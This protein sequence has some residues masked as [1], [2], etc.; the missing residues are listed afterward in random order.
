MCE[1]K[2]KRLRLH[3]F[4]V[5]STVFIINL[6]KFA[7]AAFIY[8]GQINKSNIN[9]NCYKNMCDSI[10]IIIQHALL[11]SIHCFIDL[12]PNH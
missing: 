5:V 1:I 8:F 6:Y 10:E 2:V 9:V 7:L 12:N 11:V 4:H 3:I